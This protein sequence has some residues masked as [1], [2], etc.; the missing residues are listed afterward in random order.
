MPTFTVRRCT[1]LGRAAA[2]LLLSWSG[3]AIGQVQESQVGGQSLDRPRTASAPATPEPDR[4]SLLQQ[5][6]DRSTTKAKVESRAIGG[7]PA[8]LKDNPWQVALV[9]SGGTNNVLNQFCGASIISAEWVLTAGHCIDKRLGPT[10]IEILSGVENIDEPG[11]RSKVAFYRVHPAFKTK[12]LGATF[13]HENDV[14]LLKID[15]AGPK[16][17]GQPIDGLVGSIGA[18]AEVLVTGWG[19]TERQYEP[20]TTLQF[21]AIPY[22]PNETCNGPLSYAGAVTDAMLCAGD[23]LGKKNPC[24]GDSGGSATVDISGKKRLAGI[25]SWGTGCQTP[26]LYAV[27]SRVSEYRDW[28]RKETSG[29]VSW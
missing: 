9:W 13:I 28:I 17:S 22:V 23:K 18:G 8:R 14:A 6:I 24:Y 19:V 5:A 15:A 26:H 11:V 4:P 3:F 16:L 10:S 27:F 21:V 20:T 12:R 1:L 29:A 7:K 2:I 25:V